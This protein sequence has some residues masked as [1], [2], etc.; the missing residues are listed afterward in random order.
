ML[1]WYQAPPLR[2]SLWLP[3][4]SVASLQAR[5][6]DAINIDKGNTVR[7]HNYWS[8]LSFS[9]LC[10]FFLSFLCK[11]LTPWCC[12]S[13]GA[14][15]GGLEQNHPVLQPRAGTPGQQPVHPQTQSCTHEEGTAQT[16][17]SLAA[18]S[19]DSQN[20]KA[21]LFGEPL[22]TSQERCSENAVSSRA[23]WDWCFSFLSFNSF[24]FLKRRIFFL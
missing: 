1:C 24:V 21:D 7:Q 10:I 5:H 6:A 4:N 15:G 23:Q 8:Q 13:T 2:L 17:L 19:L 20:A 18:D 9:P 14:A 22:G 16:Q 11:R 3:H 12:A